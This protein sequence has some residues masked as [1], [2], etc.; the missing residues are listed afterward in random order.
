MNVQISAPQYKSLISPGVGQLELE[1]E[2]LVDWLEENLM[3][4]LM[5]PLMMMMSAEMRIVILNQ[6]LVVWN[7]PDRIKTIIKNSFLIF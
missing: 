1:L 6:D 3:M 5:L 7:H 2:E 4:M